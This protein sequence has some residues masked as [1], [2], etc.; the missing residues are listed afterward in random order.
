MTTKTRPIDLIVANMMHEAVD[1]SETANDLVKHLEKAGLRIDGTPPLTGFAEQV[2]REMLCR[3]A[4]NAT[5]EQVFKAL[6]AVGAPCCS[7][8]INEGMRAVK[9]R[10]E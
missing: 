2:A 6:A 3:V 9:D 8:D 1:A 4:H 10:M 5:M 7:D